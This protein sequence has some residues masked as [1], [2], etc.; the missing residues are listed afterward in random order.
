[1]LRKPAVVDMIRKVAREEEQP[2]A[3][4]RRRARESLQKISAD[5]SLLW[6]KGLGAVLMPFF[7]LVYRVS[8]WT[9]QDWPACRTPRGTTAWSLC[10]V[11]NR[12]SII[13]C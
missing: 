8:T 12:T 5:F 7:Y 13:W 10:Q 6:I 3:V 2:E 9:R 4:V 11:T 1:M